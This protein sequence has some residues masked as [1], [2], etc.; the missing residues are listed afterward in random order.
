M[1]GWRRG[2]VKCGKS[3]CGGIETCRRSPSPIVAIVI[4]A[5][6]IMAAMIMASVI[7]GAVIAAIVTVAIVAVPLLIAAIHRALDQ[8]AALAAS[9]F[10]GFGGLGGFARGGGVL[11]LKPHHWAATQRQHSGMRALHTYRPCRISQ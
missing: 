5:T 11:A 6:M 3:S 4:V 8:S 9:G 1:E 10:G 2:L 7:I